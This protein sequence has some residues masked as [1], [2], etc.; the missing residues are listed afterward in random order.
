MNFSHDV[1]SDDHYRNDHQTHSIYSF[2]PLIF[3]KYL[4]QKPQQ[5]TLFFTEKRYKTAFSEVSKENEILKGKIKK[6]QSQINYFKKKTKEKKTLREKIKESWKNL[7]KSKPI[8][9]KARILELKPR[10]LRNPKN[11]RQLIHMIEHWYSISEI[12]KAFWYQRKNVVKFIR[13]HWLKSIV[14]NWK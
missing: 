12:S 4:M 3:K 9:K 14:K 2:C 6:Q 10:P 7:F 8:K 11:Q 1:H 13:R 5:G